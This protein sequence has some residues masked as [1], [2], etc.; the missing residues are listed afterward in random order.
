MVIIG[1]YSGVCKRRNGMKKVVLFDLYDT[2]LKNIS[3]DFRR[4]IAF[5]YSNYFA[6]VCTQRELEDVAETFLPLYK[7]RKEE[8]TEICLIKDEIPHFFDTFGVKQPDN[9]L[10]MDYLIMNAMQE[11]TLLEEVRHTLGELY[12]DSIG[13]YILSN[14]IFT[15]DSTKKL[16]DAF[17]ILQ[18]FNEVLVSADYGIR[19]P[20]S[21]FYDYAIERIMKDNP[22]ITKSDI[23]YVGN[24]YETDVMGAHAVGL[25]TVWYN[26]KH[27]PNHMNL[28][29]DDMD[30]FSQLIQI[31]K[32]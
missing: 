19:K 12:E 15:G 31:V 20:H 26:V 17:G 2:I 4:G 29:I 18:Y 5:L 22:G 24:D 32:R 8:H 3:F 11:V 1:G 30:E 14:S 7:R 10:D 9:L 6:A 23:L 28:E 27:L 25:D 16:L 21:A 13:M